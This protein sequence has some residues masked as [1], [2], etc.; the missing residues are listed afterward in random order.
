MKTI[1]FDGVCNLCNGSVNW[2]IDRDKKNEFTFSALQSDFAKKRLKEV[3]HADYMDSIVLDDE[4]KIFT[5]SD[6]VLRILKHLGGIYS[7]SVVFL[8]VPTFIRNFVYK[9]IANNRYKWFGKQETCR[10]PTPE[11]KAKF[12]E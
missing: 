2:I 1:L 8:I 10:V 11:L 4:G 3:G 9:T 6:A 5:E 12:L 7:L